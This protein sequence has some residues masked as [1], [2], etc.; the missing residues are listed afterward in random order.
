M[1]YLFSTSSSSRGRFRLACSTSPRSTPRRRISA[2]A[3]A[4]ARSWLRWSQGA[5]D[6]PNRTESRPSCHLLAHGTCR[7]SRT[8]S[9]D[10]GPLRGRPSGRSNRFRMARNGIDRNASGTSMASRRRWIKV[11][12]E[13]GSGAG[14]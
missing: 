3:A 1:S 7:V 4:D 8:T 14:S 9:Y 6:T 12:W 11:A 5:G 10:T 13:T 2:A